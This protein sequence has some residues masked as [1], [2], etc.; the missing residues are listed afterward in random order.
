MGNP[1]SAH[2]GVE[3]V[4]APAATAEPG[5]GRKAAAMAAIHRQLRELK[6]AAA[7]NERIDN[8]LFLAIAAMVDQA[9]DMV[10]ESRLEDAYYLISGVEHAAAH[11]G[12]QE[13]ARMARAA[14]R[15]ILWTITDVGGRA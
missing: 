15:M 5:A 7:G 4:A 9:R 6:R 1:M 3:A 8:E 2:M 12:E 10:D 13:L 14:R 11:A